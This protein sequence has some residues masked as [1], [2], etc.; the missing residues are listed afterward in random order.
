MPSFRRH[1]INPLQSQPAISPK[2]VSQELVV[3]IRSPVKEVQADDSIETHAARLLL[4]IR[5]AGGRNLRIVGRTR[6]AKLDF[7]IRYPSYL[8]KAIEIRDAD[9]ELSGEVAS[10]D[11]EMIRYRY[12]PWD[13]RYYDIFA[14]LVAKGFVSIDPSPKGDIFQLTS[15]GQFVTEELDSAEFAEVIERC[16]AVGALFHGDNGTTIKNFVYRH[17]PEVT[18]NPLWKK[19]R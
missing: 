12:G 11:S 2:D 10:P 16:T 9:V 19:I 14:L 7:F 18:A 1:M 8:K 17:F 13:S 5:Y 6:L 3:D 15:R 4:L